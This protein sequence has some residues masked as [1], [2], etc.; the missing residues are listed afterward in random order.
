MDYA[1]V[2]SNLTLT[3]VPTSI[4]YDEE[5]TTVP[6][7]ITSNN[8]AL[9]KTA[10]ISDVITGSKIKAYDQ[11]GDLMV[12]KQ[13]AKT[14]T[15]C[16]AVNN[17]LTTTE[18]AN[19]Q[20]AIAANT[21]YVTINLYRDSAVD[22][23]DGFD[24]VIL[25]STIKVRATNYVANPAGTGYFSVAIGSDTVVATTV[26]AAKSIVSDNAAE[27]AAVGAGTGPF[28][29][30]G[31]YV[32]DEDLTPVANTTLTVTEFTLGTMAGP[33]EMT[34]TTNASGQLVVGPD[35]VVTT[36]GTVTMKVL[37]KTL[38][39]TSSGGQAKLAVTSWA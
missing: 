7:T 21:G 19:A 26:K 23:G 18:D 17:T 11:F 35:A 34:L 29:L 2:S 12:T 6:E 25:G 33:T 10:T 32:L 14:V 16:T 38:T 31:T 15:S 8:V 20:F 30:T 27:T 24:I 1:E 28:T 3:Q 5:D 39:L 9:D 22:A 4:A 36:D 13:D 37:G